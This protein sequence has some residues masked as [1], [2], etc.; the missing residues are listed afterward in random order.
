[1]R[2][3]KLTQ[4]SDMLAKY[5]HLADKSDEAF[6]IEWENGEGFDFHL[7]QKTGAKIVSLTH[8]ELKALMALYHYEVE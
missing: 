1:M 7:S 5:C 2:I 3:A 8:G 4:K 6:F